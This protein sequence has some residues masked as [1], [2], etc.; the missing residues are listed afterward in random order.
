MA[1][2]SSLGAWSTSPVDLV[3]VGGVGRRT[4]PGT[5]ARPRP[6]SPSPRC[7][8]PTSRRPPR[9]P[10]SA[11]SPIRTSTSSTGTSSAS[12]AICGS[13]VQVPVPRSAAP[14]SADVPAASNADRRGRL[15]HPH[16]SGTSRRRRRCRPASSPSRRTP[17]RGSRS[18]QPNR[19]RA[20]AQALHQVPA[21]P[22]LAGLG[23][24]VGLVAD[25]QLDRVDAE[26]PASSSI[27]TSGPNMPGHSPG[28]RIQDGTGTSSA[29]SRCV[30]R[31]FGAAYIIRVGDAGLLGELLDPRGLLDHVDRDRGQRARRGR[32]RAA[33]AGSSACGSRRGRTSAG[34]SAPAS[35]AGPAA[36][37]RPSRPGRRGRAACP[38]TRT[39]RRRTGRPPGPAPRPARTPRPRPPGPGARPGWSP[40]G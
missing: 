1:C 18:S 10:G 24:D 32:R 30:V 4:C 16:A 5:R 11:V 35:P 15:R 34:G 31:R 33:A 38:S 20:L 3:A 21:R 9:P 7:S 40:T 2:A 8:C 6:R 19:A 28:A 12:A 26:R 37:A 25:P 27:A 29:A 39:R 22:R 14:I 23:V 36:P 13:T 17:G